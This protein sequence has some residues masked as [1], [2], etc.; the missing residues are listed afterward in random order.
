MS[1][2]LTNKT[3]LDLLNKQLYIEETHKIIDILK[4]IY[5]N[6]IKYINF[7]LKYDKLI[8]IN[9]D[10]CINTDI[11]INPIL[12]QFGHIIFFYYDNTLKLLETK[13]NFKFHLLNTYIKFFHKYY[14]T[15]TLYNSE[16]TSKNLRFKYTKKNFK[17]LKLIYYSI[18]KTLINY[19]NI[20]IIDSIDTYLILLSILHNDMHNE[21]FIFTM[22]YL[23]INTTNLFPYNILSSITNTNINKY[24]KI[25]GG[26]FNQGSIINSNNFTFDNEMPSFNTYVNTI[27][28][29]QYPI[30][31]YEYLQFVINNGY[32]IDEYWTIES[33]EWKNN[34]NIISPIYWF[35]KNNS[36]YKLHWNTIIPVGSNIPIINISWYEAQAYCKWNKCRLITETE[37]EYLATNK[38]TTLYPW[39]NT[40]PNIHN[41][42]IN[43][44][45]NFCVDVNLYENGN[46]HDNVSQ[47]IGNI[48]EWCLEPIYPY[49]NFTIDPIYR[50]MSYPYF[51]KKKICKGGCFCVSDYLINSKYRNAQYSDCRI[52][53]IGF[54]I[55]KL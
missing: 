53:F 23:H 15:S 28:V 4:N 9:T 54:R 35:K 1:L 6:T 37:W 50:E 25:D 52:Q 3:K 29:T 8:D 13:N 31:E 22:Y 36:W 11:C 45:N 55:C 49:N 30:T 21:N 16:I 27:N 40:K 48:W 34:N 38:G 46:N 20:N 32:L 2:Y 14:N 18:I 5:K 47:L 39:G 44:I 43:N 7:L 19:L 42:N 10:N 33:L 26:F 41:C 12:W 24:I 51:G 17:Q